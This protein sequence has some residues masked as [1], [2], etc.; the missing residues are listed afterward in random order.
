MEVGENERQGAAW[1]LRFPCMHTSPA[2]QDDGSCAKVAETR[3]G[4]RSP[5]EQRWVNCCLVRA[6]LFDFFLRREGNGDGGF[7]AAWAE[8][9]AVGVV[10]LSVGHSSC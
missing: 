2:S 8:S 5:V 6:S 3:E 4:W 9:E 7:G 10:N 1:P